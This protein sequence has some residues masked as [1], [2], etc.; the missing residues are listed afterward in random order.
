MKHLLLIACLGLAAC[1]A[2]KTPLQEAAERYGYLKRNGGN[3]ADLCAA[4]RDAKAAVLA[5]QGP[6]VDFVGWRD[7]EKRHCQDGRIDA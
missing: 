1:Q 3:V 4:A 7:V 5:E 2:P 6:P